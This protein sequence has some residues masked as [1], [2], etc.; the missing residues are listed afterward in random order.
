MK[1]EGQ[2][3]SRCGKCRY[4]FRQSKMFGDC[5]KWKAAGRNTLAGA[6]ETQC[7][8]FKK[9]STTPAGENCK[10][11]ADSKVGANPTSTTK[12]TKGGE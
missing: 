9:K 11:V 3:V 5:S 4:Y 7:G 10:S 2:V 1:I 8:E 12:P 6:F